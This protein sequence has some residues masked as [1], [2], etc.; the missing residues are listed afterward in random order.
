M[1]SLIVYKKPADGGRFSIDA[2]CGLIVVVLFVVFVFLDPGIVFVFVLFFVLIPIFD[3]IVVNN[4]IDGEFVV[5][6][7]HQTALIGIKVNLSRTAI[8]LIQESAVQIFASNFCSHYSPPCT[9]SSA[10]GGNP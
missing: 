10:E 3:V 4:I 2:D 1:N 9:A 7:E 6:L 8:S 5:R